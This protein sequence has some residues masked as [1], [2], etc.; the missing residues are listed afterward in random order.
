MSAEQTFPHDHEQDDDRTENKDE[1]CAEHA[2][3]LGKEPVDDGPQ[4]TAGR[5][6]CNLQFKEKG[7]HRDDDD[8][9]R[10]AEQEPYADG[11][12]LLEQV[13]VSEVAENQGYDEKVKTNE[14][15]KP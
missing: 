1:I 7:Q 3:I 13:Y 10:Y 5:D 15:E 9:N 14:P 11:F 8:T 4:F 2:E 6:T 12:F